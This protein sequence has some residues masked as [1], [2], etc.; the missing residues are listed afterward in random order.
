MDLLEVDQRFSYHS[1]KGNQSQRYVELRDTAR[2]YVVLILELC[3]D[4]RERS[5]AI[6]KLEEA[7]M[8]ANASIARRE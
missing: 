6:R 3:P 7:V 4:S 2:Q 8:W 5:V 1:P